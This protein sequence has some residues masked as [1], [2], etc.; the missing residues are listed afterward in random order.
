[1]IEKLSKT[2]GTVLVSNNFFSIP[3]KISSQ[4]KEQVNGTIM[5][6]V[7]YLQSI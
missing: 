7:Q 5:V 2:M 4:L 1:M 6:A 3:S